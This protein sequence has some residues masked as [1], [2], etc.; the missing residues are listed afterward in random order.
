M[1]SSSS[2]TPKLENPIVLVH[3]LG[4][5]AAYGPIDYFFGLPAKLK[6]AGNRVFVANLTSWHTIKHRAAE[7]KR[8]IEEA[9]PDER[10]NIVSHS[11][12]GL[13]SR[14]LVSKLDFAERVTSVTTI[15]TPH[16]GST[17][18]DIASGIFPEATFAALDRLLG[19]ME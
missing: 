5:K 16:R 13:D 18:G 4:A 8:Q 12:G 14:Y 2:G 11:M 3:G 9:F 6:Q 10:V 17:L 15:G 1:A 7:L 19:T